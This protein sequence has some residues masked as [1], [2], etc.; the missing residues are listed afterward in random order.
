MLLPITLVFIL[1]RRKWKVLAINA[2]KSNSN[3]TNCASKCD[4][5]LLLCSFSLLHTCL[6]LFVLT[7]E[8]ADFQPQ[9]F[10]YKQIIFKFLIDFIFELLISTPKPVSHS[11]RTEPTTWRQRGLSFC[12]EK[13]PENQ[14][15]TT[16]EQSRLQLI[17]VT[18]AL[19]LEID[20]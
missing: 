14:C 20:N 7:K 13:D 11:W 5:I 8:Q 9:L 19:H 18:L 10:F 17:L 3:L 15:I 1:I 4:L 16:L 6:S 12:K 2:M